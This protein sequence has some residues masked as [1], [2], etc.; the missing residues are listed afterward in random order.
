MHGLAGSTLWKQWQIDL[1]YRYKR[2]KTSRIKVLN[3]L[4][5]HFYFLLFKLY[6][7]FEWSWKK[8]FKLPP[9]KIESF[10][11]LPSNNGHFA[12]AIFINSVSYEV[13]NVFLL[14]TSLARGTRNFYFS[15]VESASPLKNDTHVTLGQFFIDLFVYRPNYLPN[16]TS[17]NLFIITGPMQVSKVHTRKGTFTHCD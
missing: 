15:L 5:L 10:H 9:G 12:F 7:Y 14:R 16:S 13:F 3:I 2:A 17:P 11:N 8:N 6:V 1:P 4:K